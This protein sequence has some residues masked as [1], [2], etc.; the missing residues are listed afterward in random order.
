MCREWFLGITNL[1]YCFT[2]C[3]I[4]LQFFICTTIPYFST[5]R[6]KSLSHRCR[7]QPDC[8]L[9]RYFLHLRYKNSLKPHQIPPTVYRNR[10]ISLAAIQFPRNRPLFS[11]LLYCN[12]FTDMPAVHSVCHYK[13]L[14]PFLY[15]RLPITAP[16]IQDTCLPRP[17]GGKLK[18]DDSR[19][20]SEMP[21]TPAGRQRRAHFRF[22]YEVPYITLCSASYST[23]LR[24]PL[25]HSFAVSLSTALK[26]PY[27]TSYRTL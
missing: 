12:S 21:S 17:P 23:P 10:E 16:A 14:L 24:C 5:F 15:C 11:L 27:K 20:D 6:Y 1:Y 9:G 19:K 4:C 7:A 22:P 18:N 25:Q 8:I 2:I 26:A 3:L 13:R